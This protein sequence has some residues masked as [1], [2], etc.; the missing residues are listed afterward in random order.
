MHTFDSARPTVKRW[1]TAGAIALTLA[2]A[3]QSPALD[4]QSSV[5]G[6]WRTLPYLMPINPVHLALTND[7]KVLVV[8]GSGIRRTTRS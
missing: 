2:L 6:Q 1:L 5:Q 7:G 4:A 3:L 8:A